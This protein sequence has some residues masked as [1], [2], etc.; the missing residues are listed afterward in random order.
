MV[1][2]IKK[3]DGDCK[4]VYGRPRHPQSQGLVEQ[5]NGTIERMIASAM[6][7]EKTK[8]WSKLLP[9]IQF[10]LNSQKTS[11]VKNSPFE[12]FFNKKPNFGSKKEFVQNDKNG[13]EVECQEFVENDQVVEKVVENNVEAEV[14]ENNAESEAEDEEEDDEINT[15][16]Q[17]KRAELNLVKKKNRAIMIRKH[18]HKR[19]KKTREFAIGDTVSVQIPS[20]DRAGTD[21]RRLAGKIC[22]ISEHKQKFYYILTQWGILNDKYLESA[23]EPYSGLVD[24]ALEDFE[25]NFKTISL[26]EASSLQS[27]N[28]GSLETVK[29]KCNCGMFCKGDNRCNCFKNGVKCTSHCHSKKGGK[30][31]KNC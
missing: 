26:R 24:V 28:T 3:W 8:E 20:I 19:N 23:L 13:N 22:K 1:D 30:T 5:S 11:G 21:F 2:L 9:R 7:Q 4:L 6:E 25:K 18:D 16:I 15:S 31:C 14:A 29:R 17:R 27:C 10:N 12:I